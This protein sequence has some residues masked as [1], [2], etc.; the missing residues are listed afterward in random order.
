IH[1]DRLGVAPTEGKSLAPGGGLA[2]ALG[3]AEIARH[4]AKRRLHPR[5]IDSQQPDPVAQLGE[6]A[7]RLPP[8]LQSYSVPVNR[9]LA[10]CRLLTRQRRRRAWP[11]RPSS[12]STP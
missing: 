7:H 3:V 5:R 6:H 9:A 2:V 12:P 4:P 10:P 11:P 8:L 1:R